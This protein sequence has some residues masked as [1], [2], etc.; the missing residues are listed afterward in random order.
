MNNF[1]CDYKLKQCAEGVN[2]CAEKRN[3][4]VSNHVLDFAYPTG[5]SA[6]TIMQEMQLD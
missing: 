4:N 1:F 3:G 2:A 5:R 6:E